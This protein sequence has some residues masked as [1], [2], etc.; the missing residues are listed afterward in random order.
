MCD[1]AMNGRIFAGDSP[2][3]SMTDES[4]PL[5]AIFRD[6]NPRTRESQF[7]QPPQSTAQKS[8]STTLAAV[9]RE[10]QFRGH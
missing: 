2:Y 6:Q 9:L 5:A 7:L 1:F 4:E 10:A 3:M 8:S